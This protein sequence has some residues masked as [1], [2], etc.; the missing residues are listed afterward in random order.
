[1]KKIDKNMYE[2]F[3]PY[4]FSDLEDLAQARKT[5]AKRS[6][7]RMV[8]LEEGKSPITG[9]SYDYGA[10]ENAKQYIATT[11]TATKSGKLRF[12]ESASYMKNNATALRREIIELQSFLG[13]KSSTIK[14]MRDIEKMRINAFESGKWKGKTKLK[15]TSNKSFYNFLNSKTYNQLK[16]SGFTSEQIVDM[17]D[18]TRDKTGSFRETDKKMRQAIKDIKEFQEKGKQTSIKEL[19]KM[20]GIEPIIIPKED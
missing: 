3:N 11:R 12:S 16:N 6:N 10:I 17:Y 5:L 7:Q 2:T 20:L 4:K 19:S 9:E 15:F 1:M 8:R 13:A 14:G 18:R